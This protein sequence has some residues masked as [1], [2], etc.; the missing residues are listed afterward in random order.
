MSNRYEIIQSVSGASLGVYEG[1]DEDEAIQAMHRDAGAPDAETDPGIRAIEVSPAVYREQAEEDAIRE[2]S[3]DVPTDAPGV[4]AV[5]GYDY[6]EG[7][8][9]WPEAE[10][11]YADAYEAKL[12]ELAEADE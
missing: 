6:P 9:G 2:W 12:R 5:D 8:E 10:A 1:D 3:S 7:C 4:G 11:E